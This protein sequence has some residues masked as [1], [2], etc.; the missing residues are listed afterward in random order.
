MYIFDNMEC[1]FGYT[2]EIL[3]PA[4]ATILD[5]YRLMIHFM[6]RCKGVYHYL[7]ATLFLI[8]HMKTKASFS[9]KYIICMIYLHL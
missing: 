4:W 7:C 6:N 2:E 3:L 5:A 9:I 8:L 1:M